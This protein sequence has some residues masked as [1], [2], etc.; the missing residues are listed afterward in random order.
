MRELVVISGKGGTGK[1]SVVASFAALAEGAVLA[2]CDVDAADLHLLLAPQVEHRETFSGGRVASIRSEACTGCG[3]CLEHC[4][5]GAV[6]VGGNEGKTCRV[7]PIACDGC[8]VCALVC[9]E[10]A[11]R[12]NDRINGEWFVSATRHGPMVHARLGIAESNSGK[13]V[14]LVRRKARE[15]AES[16]GRG[17]VLI[18]GPPGIGCPVIASI[19]G[20]SL[21]VVVTEPTLSGIHD[22]KRVVDLA[23][24]FGIPGAVLVN[25]H[26]LNPDLTGSIEAFCRERGLP[27]LGR[28]PYDLAVTRAQL[29]GRAVVEADRGPA[30]EGIRRGWEQTERQLGLE[31]A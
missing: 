24:H 2:D 29:A 26:D 4:R 9:D 7:D 19:A 16:Q 6:L 14:T 15:I 10:G 28:I 11:V 27:V 17:L 13:L 20:T 21:V 8:G 5:F 1:T 25:K 30:A 3:R 23:A 31:R 18:D 22:L 12:L